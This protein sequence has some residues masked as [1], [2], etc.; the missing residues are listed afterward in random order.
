MGPDRA[1]CSK[2]PTTGKRRRNPRAARSVLRMLFEL[3]RDAVQAVAQSGRRR[4]IVE[5]VTEMRAA[6]RAKN[7]I[8]LHAETVVFH[9]RDD[10]GDKRFGKT[11]PASAGFELRVAREQQRVASGA[12]ENAAAMF[13]QQ[14]GGTRALGRVATENRI[15]LR[16]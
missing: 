10:P 15:L 13:R 3:Q 14:D 1:P 2:H 7:F 12:M 4:A 9:G 5:N 8:A 11:G 6:T 16:R